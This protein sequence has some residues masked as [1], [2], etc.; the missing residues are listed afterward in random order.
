MFRRILVPLDGSAR[1]ER[2]I[3]LAARLARASGGS[4]ILLRVVVSPIE[5]VWQPREPAESMQES[6]DTEQAGA[7]E[8]LV[9]ISAL[10]VLAGV[11]TSTQVFRGIPAAGILSIARSQQ[12]DLIVLCSHGYTD[13]IRWAMGSVAQKVAFHAP[14][15]VL[16]LRENGPVPAALP[17]GSG[18][19]PL[20][21]LVAL[22]GSQRAEKGIEYAAVMIAAL[23]APDPGDLHL[24]RVVKP[25]SDEDESEAELRRAG[26]YLDA[27]AK[28]LREGRA[29]P[30]IADFP[31]TVTTAVVVDDDEAGALI[32]VAEKGEGAMASGC[33]FIA[34]TTHG[35]SGIAR[36]ALG[37]ITERV[38]K[39][40]NLPLL[41]VRPLDIMEKSNF[42]W[43]DTSLS[44]M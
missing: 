26:E 36:W 37:S 16:V 25:V 20:R 11:A 43:D 8:Y 14:N 38:L 2:A 19:R 29:A 24:T 40:S 31:L 17:T 44:P 30:A 7:A 15:P 35:Y 23:A 41:I 9:R 34:M 39:A 28:R 3:P 27:T 18:A 33:D 13:V 5:P 12:V 10:D 6:P 1:A 42:T 32:R 22:D 4:I 21:A